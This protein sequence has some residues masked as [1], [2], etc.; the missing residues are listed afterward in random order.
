M[1]TKRTKT[2]R[3]KANA[4]DIGDDLVIV[5]M[6]RRIAATGTWVTGN[7]VY[8]LMWWCRRNC[9]GRRAMVSVDNTLIS[10]SNGG[11]PPRKEKSPCLKICTGGEPIGISTDLALLCKNA[12]GF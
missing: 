7:V 9:L 11:A 10:G 4:A 6:T 1:T 2:N 12:S 5:R 8:L 3:T